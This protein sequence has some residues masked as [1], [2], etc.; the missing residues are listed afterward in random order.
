MHVVKK[1]WLCE[2]DHQKHGS[3]LI[4]QVLARYSCSILHIMGLASTYKIL[5]DA[6]ARS[7]KN[8]RLARSCKHMHRCMNCDF[9][10]L[11]GYPTMVKI[12]IFFLGITIY[13]AKAIKN[14]KKTIFKQKICQE[15]LRALYEKK[16]PET[17][18]WPPRSNID[19]FRGLPLLFKIN[20]W[21]IAPY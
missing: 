19:V 7:C 9:D 2:T 1:R 18:C 16:G 8:D 15:P 3:W 4:L 11:G 12:D 6:L 17:I 5:Q 10:F 14:V 21:G 20:F 13:T